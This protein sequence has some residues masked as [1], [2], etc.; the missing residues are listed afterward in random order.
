MARIAGVNIPTAKR[1]I[2]ALTYVTGIGHTSAAAICE[3]VGIDDGYVMTGMAAGNNWF[4]RTD[5]G[6]GIVWQRSYEFAA[7]AVAS[8]IVLGPGDT[9]VG[10]GRDLRSA[11]GWFLRAP[12]SS[13]IVGAGCNVIDTTCDVDSVGNVT[14]FNSDT[15]VAVGSMGIDDNPAVTVSN[16]T[17][18]R[19]F[20]CSEVN[21]EEFVMGD[22][23]EGGDFGGWSDVFE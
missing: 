23:F 22:D 14:E 8:N 7:G 9:F 21:P 15:P 3:A 18:N 11:G 10:I 6:G 2:I 16:L 5:L 4:V 17:A 12:I 20:D 1:V 19:Q 13:G